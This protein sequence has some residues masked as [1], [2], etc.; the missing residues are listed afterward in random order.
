MSYTLYSTGYNVQLNAH[1]FPVSNKICIKTLGFLSRSE[2]DALVEESLLMS[3]FDHRNVM[4]LI[5]VSIENNN[6]LYIVMP[7][8]THGSLLSYLRNHRT[9]LTLDRE[10]DDDLVRRKT[11]GSPI[12]FSKE[13]IIEVLISG[14]VIIIYKIFLGKITDCQPFLLLKGAGLPKMF[15]SGIMFIR[16]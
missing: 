10:E 12:I 15:R 4:K 8:M 2:L 9:E 3:R 1:F 5:G 14:I 11:R 13:K 16:Q 7:F 6:T